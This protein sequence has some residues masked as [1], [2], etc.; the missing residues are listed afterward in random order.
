MTLTGAAAGPE[1]LTTN[2]ACTVPASPSVT[3]ASAM[4]R[5]GRSSLRIV[6]TPS[7]SPIVAFCSSDRTTAKVSSAS[8][9]TSPI[10][11][12]S[13]VRVVSPGANV[14]VPEAAA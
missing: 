3:V 14:T 5:V 6:T 12:S 10:T 11:R 7:P 13:I 4:P 2:T 1:R 9:E 8:G